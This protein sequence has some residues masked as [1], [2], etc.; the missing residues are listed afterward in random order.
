MSRLFWWLLGISIVCGIATT[1]VFLCKKNLRKWT[2]LAFLVAPIVAFLGG[3]AIYLAVMASLGLI[4]VVLLPVGSMVS[5]VASVVWILKILM[6][7]YRRVIKK[8]RFGLVETFLLYGFAHKHKFYFSLIALALIAASL[9]YGNTLYFLFG[10]RSLTREYRGV[11]C[12][13]VNIRQLGKSTEYI[14]PAQIRVDMEQMGGN[15]EDDDVYTQRYYYIEY[16]YF[17]NGGYLDFTYNGAYAEDLIHSVY[18]EERDGTAWECTVLNEHA[19]SPMVEETQRV[20]PRAVIELVFM[21]VGLLYNWLG[22]IIYEEKKEAI[23]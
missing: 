19:Y 22:G 11:Y 8:I 10:G 17:S 2:W 18:I 15:T 1:I 12:Y 9:F 4:V 6:L 21:I 5:F 13:Y 3:G 14:L 23:A 20:K 16:V 7:V